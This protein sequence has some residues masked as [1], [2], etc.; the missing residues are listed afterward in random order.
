MR[1]SFLTN[2]LLL[3][4]LNGLVKPFYVLGIDA[5]VQRAAGSEAYGAY[6][7]LLSLS[8]LLNIVL[9]L[10]LTNFNTRHIARHTPLMAKYLG[11]MAALRGALALA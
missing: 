2:L 9:D 6:A 11:S 4:A 1:R 3:L 8:F 5:G 7:A 10:G